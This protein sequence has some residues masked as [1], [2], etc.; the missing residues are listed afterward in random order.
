MAWL[1]GWDHRVKLSIDH[2]DI[3]G[4]LEDFP[5]LLHL[6]TSSGISGDDLSFIF[7]EV[8]ANSLKIAVTEDDGETECYVEV[9]KWDNGNEEAWL[10]IKVPAVASG[11]DTDI[12]LYFDNV[13]ADNNAHVGI[14]NSV[15]AEN[16]WDASF[17]AV[18]HMRDDPDNTAIR[19]STSGDY[20]GAKAGA[21]QPA[22]V[23]AG[24][25]DGAQD[26]DGADDFVNMGDVLDIL[27]NQDFTLEAIIKSEAEHVGFI[28]NKATQFG[29]T[30]FDMY[31]NVD[32]IKARVGIG[33]AVGMVGVAAIV[34]G[35][36]YYLAASF[37]RDANGQLYTN[38]ATDGAA[39]DISGKAGDTS[40]AQDL[41]IGYRED[42]HS[43]HFDGI[44][45]EVRI[46]WT[47]RNAAW[48]KAT[49]ESSIDD[50]LDYGAVEHEASVDLL[51]RVV[52][53]HGD[54]ET[55]LVKALIQHSGSANLLAKV[56]IKGVTSEDLLGKFEVRHAS[57]S[58][59]LGHFKVRHIG[60]AQ[61]LLGKIIIR[62]E[63]SANLLAKTVIK[64]VT[65]E[66]LLARLEV[67]RASSA[68]LL[69]HFKVRHIGTAQ[70]LLGKIIIRHDGS[71]NLL[72]KLVVEVGVSAALLAKIIVRN[73][74][75]ANL[76]SKLIVRHA[77]S[78]NLLTRFRVNCPRR[79]GGN[80]QRKMW[81]YNGYYW[82]GRYD[83]D[84]DEIIF[85]Y[86]IEAGLAGNVW[87]KNAAASIDA[88]AFTGIIADFTVRG[89]EDGL[90]TTI[91]YSDGMDTWIAES[92]EASDVGWA[93]QNLTKVFDGTDPD[94]YR[95]VNLAANR[96]TPTPRLWAIAVFYDQSEGKQWVKARR[97]STGGDITGWDAA[98]D[99]SNVDN[100]AEIKGNTIRS[101]GAKGVTKND[102]MVVY[103]EGAAL[104]SRYYTGSWQA[105]QDIDTTAITGK[106]AFDF[107]HGEDADEDEGHILYVDADGSIQFKRRA[108]GGAEI[109]AA[110]DQVYGVVQPPYG[111]GIIE[112]GS[113]WLWSIWADGSGT[114][115]R[116]RLYLCATDTWYPPLVNN[117]LSFDTTTTPPAV[118]TTIST[119][120]LH[121]PDSIP[122][123]DAVPIC[124][125]GET[126]PSSPCS[127]A[128]GILREAAEEDL[129][130]KFIIK[131]AGSADLLGKFHVGQGSQ[132][133]LG[134]FEVRHGNSAD[135]LGKLGIRQLGS[136]D[137][138]GKF[139]VRHSSDAD[140]LGKLEIRH[141]ASENLLGKFEIK[142]P[143]SAD[144]LG[145]FAVSNASSE[146]LLAKFAVRHD[147][148]VD[149]LG[150]LE[151]E[152]DG[153]K[154]LLA[155]FKVRHEGTQNLKA[156]VDIRH[157]SYA[158]LFTKIILR[159]ASS[160]DLLGRLEIR[161][162]AAV[163]LLAKVKIRHGGAGAAQNLKAIVD[164]RLGASS[165]LL[166]KFEVRHS[167]SADLLGKFTVSNANSED[168]L[169]RVIIR[170]LAFADLLGRLE[171]R[172][173]SSENL[174]AI[175]D[176][177]HIS[178]ANLLGR[179]EIRH[180]SSEDL[181]TK[182]T[183][184]HDAAVDLLAKF[185]VRH[186]ASVD[187]LSKFAVRNTGSADL[188]AHFNLEHARAGALLAHFIVR[189]STSTNLLAK[190]EVENS[191][192]ADLLGRLEVRS[193]SS[194][195]LLSKFIV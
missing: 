55:L 113:G 22:L 74:S 20:D 102:V 18:Y 188:L 23:A 125:I 68:D 163:D 1:S 158:N 27:A 146:V 98:V 71:A 178:S 192:F 139:E 52:L 21:G 8:G 35:N 41:A 93:W 59:L 179:L 181:V 51:A 16:V 10:W 83:P 150:K 191:S 133:L 19:D 78:S 185:A 50:L 183:I 104:R 161:H 5:V 189:H 134:K 100:T 9:E 105:I 39:V 165:N 14:T 48:I 106:A 148:S 82:R 151:V 70:N 190:F 28:I 141:D 108:A 32:D 111:L 131:N 107:E 42:D 136:A 164:I 112:H 25:I 94:W 120:Q 96:T 180:A 24:P 29:H 72:A 86:I 145:K 7:D 162:D 97:Q 169:A 31:L 174:K 155:K 157:D 186:D 137:L 167:S 89:P 143:G 47:I 46:S 60:T 123:G 170:N 79:M 91:H 147:A 61:N 128:W 130:S 115:I 57:S 63:A 117:P 36:Q 80:W 75:S 4:A 87:T 69:G 81:I 58:G 77:S 99:I 140:L 149:L 65:S 43:N 44:I 168:L 160:A 85:E 135:L 193:S 124:W 118:I 37:D 3:T 182:L 54:S 195:G 6:S 84:A 56:I 154:D 184:R 101:M 33:G 126:A 53:R 119:A 144:L 132:D 121:T 40:N 76:L 92:D 15:P 45:D 49:Y 26:F 176:I 194:A 103:K 64:G 13:H 152:H 122:A 129:L 173:G 17:K 153:S 30:G 171:V 11:A 12:Y 109:W 114:L 34:P 142:Q 88:S 67:R 73:T 127:P 62:H 175:V 159:N 166:G 66:D 38:G 116:Y 110:A 2:D 90:R 177:R 95:Q 187:L 172:P 138:L 156:V